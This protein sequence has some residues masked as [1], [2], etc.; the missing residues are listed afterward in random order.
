MLYPM[1][2]KGELHRLKLTQKELRM[3][4]YI[5]YS[6]PYR[7]WRERDLDLLAEARKR[8][9]AGDNVQQHQLDILQ[10]LYKERLDKAKRL[11]TAMFED[12]PNRYLLKFE[13]LGF[14]LNEME[15]YYLALKSSYD[16]MMYFLRQIRRSEMDPEIKLTKDDYALAMKCTY[17]HFAPKAAD[18]QP[19]S[20]QEGER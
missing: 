6:S 19:S 18:V 14:S 15:E 12:L 3:C 9:A 17:A 5:R 7:F 10:V 11:Q 4:K 16:V 13:K 2:Q 1:Y 8:I 20:P